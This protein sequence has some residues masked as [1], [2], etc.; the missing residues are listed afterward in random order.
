MITLKFTGTH[1]E[2]V[3]DIKSLLAKLE[4]ATVPVEITRTERTATEAPSEPAE[5]PVEKVEEEP[6]PAPE[7]PAAS[8]TEEPSTD[9]VKAVLINL[10]NKRGSAV[11]RNLLARFDATRFGELDHT[12]YAEVMKAAEEEIEHGSN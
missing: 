6:T 8:A 10:R 7:E 11:L 1:D 2:I 4:A 3:A 12:R 5:A 9:D